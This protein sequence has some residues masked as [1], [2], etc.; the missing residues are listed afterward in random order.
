[1][2]TGLTLLFAVDPSARSRLNTAFVTGN[3]IGGA[4]GSALAGLLWQRGGW[5]AVMLG[6]GVLIGLALVV[7]V[8]QRGRALAVASRQAAPSAH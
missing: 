1:M 3:F 6:G 4:V 5:L 8:T 7:W 2:S